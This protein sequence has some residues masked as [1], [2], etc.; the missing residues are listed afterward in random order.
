MHLC[1]FCFQA[2][3]V[4]VCTVKYHS[5]KTKQLHTNLSITWHVLCRLS[6]LKSYFKFLLQNAEWGFHFI[7]HKSQG[8]ICIPNTLH[9]VCSFFYSFFRLRFIHSFTVHTITICLPILDHFILMLTSTKP[10]DSVVWLALSHCRGPR[11]FM[12]EWWTL[13]N[14]YIPCYQ[15]QLTIV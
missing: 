3:H 4:N 10:C 8:K 11:C 1:D 5:I 7:I 15:S 14:P 12:T 6:E 9:Y 13:I 2:I